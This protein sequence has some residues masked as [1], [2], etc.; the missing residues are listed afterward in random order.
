[1]FNCQLSGLKPH[2]GSPRPL[3]LKESHRLRSLPNPS[4]MS[5]NWS[6][7]RKDSGP[8]S[9]LRKS[10]GSIRKLL[11]SMPKESR[12]SDTWSMLKT[13]SRNLK[14]STLSLKLQLRF[15]LFRTK[16]LLWVQIRLLR[17]WT[18]NC[19][20][21]KRA[22]GSKSQ[23]ETWESSFCLKKSTDWTIRSELYCQ[24]NPLPSHLLTSN[25]YWD[26]TKTSNSSFRKSSATWDKPKTTSD[27]WWGKTKV[28]PRK[29]TNWSV[30]STSSDSDETK[31]S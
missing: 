1:M 17:S 12:S 9:C 6:G 3:S 27:S 28:L 4:P 22:Q 11:S 8:S 5:L 20:R 18:T 2:N 19:W 15:Q 23:L 10:T 29:E 31:I 13:S 21:S 14:W 16:S 25:L 30:K 24:N 7:L 26:K